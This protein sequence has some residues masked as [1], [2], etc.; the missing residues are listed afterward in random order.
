MPAYPDEQDDPEKKDV[1]HGVIF[2]IC[3][4]CG[5]EGHLEELVSTKKMSV[6]RLGKLRSRMRRMR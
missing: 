4:R 3:R 6:T 5:W 1:V 2:Y